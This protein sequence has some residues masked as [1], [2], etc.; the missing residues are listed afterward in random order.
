MNQITFNVCLLI[1]TLLA[2]I[3]LAVFVYRRNRE[4]PLNRICA[5][6]SLNIAIWSF[7]VLMALISHSPGSFILWVKVVFIFNVFLP[8]NIYLFVIALSRNKLPSWTKCAMVYVIGS[9]PSIA[10]GTHLVVKGCEV[11]QS[12]QMT[13]VYGAALPIFFFYFA[14]FLGGTLW[15][16]AAVIKKQSGIKR[17]QFQYVF[18]GLLLFSILSVCTGLIAPLAGIVET[19]V[20]SLTPVFALMW[21]CFIVYAIAK[22]HLMDITIVI[23]RTTL[24]A[25][26]TA[27]ITAGYIGIVLLSNWLFGG[28]MGLQTLV[29][30]MVAALLIAFAFAPVKEAIQA[31]IDKTLFK[32]RYDHHKILSDLSRIL[33]SIYSLEELLSLI[34]RVITKA[35]GV[36]RGSIFLPQYPGRVFIA[37]AHHGNGGAIGD[38]R[39]VAQ[40]SSLIRKLH[41]RRDLIIREQLERLPKS[42]ETREVVALLEGLKADICIPIFSKDTLTGMLFLGSKE[43]GEAFTSEDIEMFNTLSHHIAVAIENAQLYTKVEESKIYQE[44]LLNNLT[45]GV[46]AIDLSGRITAFNA[47][48][49]KML[50]VR[51]SRALGADLKL[52]P[53]ELRDVL[54]DTLK[55]RV[56]VSAE[57]VVI[58][59]DSNKDVPLA[60]SSS[61]FNSYDGK[62]L[63]AL[64]V[65]SDLTERK[66]LEMEMRRADR[67]AS[68]GTLAAG[69]AHEIK[70]PLVALKT[71]T[72]LLPEKYS[73]REFRENF[74]KLA[75]Q[76]VDR[77]NYLVEQLLDFARPS[78]PSFRK[79]DVSEILVNTLFLLRSKIAEQNV[80]VREEI[81]KRPLMVMADGDQLK[82]VLLNII[83][84]ALQAMDEKGVLTVKAGIR[85]ATEPETASVRGEGL[86]RRLHRLWS[87]DCV[88]IELAD[89]GKGIE[90]KDLP[91]LFDPFFTTKESGAGLGL[92]IAHSI[93]E[94]H[95]GI[96]DVKSVV[97]EGTAFLITLPMLPQESPV[98]AACR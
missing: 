28:I 82:Q 91:H 36:E 10:S 88:V 3:T 21:V 97:G 11:N 22:Y 57:E 70:N 90:P 98:S 42:R 86:A 24:Y 71:F 45:S 77:I 74:S 63:G 51:A 33:T 79:T 52:L 54:F 64:I 16:L 59:L 32:K 43:T 39:P 7:A 49:E 46:V 25:L 50:G 27:S 68:L 78:L 40:D 23:K 69:M 62:T 67:L 89:T 4:N 14:V 35:M 6:L 76:E 53:S 66:V 55:N 13:V 61:I 95:G 17:L 56:S 19:Q 75:N 2:A 26:L 20:A 93:I 30:A 80:E 47:R 84:N 96:V 9:L 37:M 12:G 1:F 18:L 15:Y 41:W 87:Q 72:Q 31:F 29:P 58:K 81:E 38:Y 5:V 94:E 83:I 48:A 8:P 92:A 44:I 85:G 73:D 60:V 65:F 34:L